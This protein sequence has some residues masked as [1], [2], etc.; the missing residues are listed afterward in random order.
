MLQFKITTK[1]APRLSLLA[2]IT[3]IAAVTFA[4]T[5]FA[6]VAEPNPGSDLLTPD[7]HVLILTDRQPQMAF[8]VRS[9]DGA[10]ME[11]GGAALAKF[12]KTFQVPTV[13]TTVAAETFSGPI[14]PENA[15]V[16][17]EQVP[18]DRSTMTARED[19]GFIDEV[20]RHG[21]GKVVT[22]TSGG[23]WEEA[24]TMAIQ[25]MAPQAGATPITWMRY[26]LE[27]RRDRAR[28]AAY[29]DITTVMREDGGGYGPAI[30]YAYQMFHLHEGN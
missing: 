3:V 11:D 7:N 22:D 23:V 17:P 12:G 15:I 16:F 4:F 21:K 30:A 25:R 14:L 1:R 10:E 13:L 20:N 18:I 28:Q 6:Q 29:A 24:Q 8:A 5:A 2:T 26:G 27:L 9:H 19:K